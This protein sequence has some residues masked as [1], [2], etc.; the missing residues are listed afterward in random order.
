MQDVP[1]DTIHPLDFAYTVFVSMDDYRYTALDLS[2][3]GRKVDS[4]SLVQSTVNYS[5]LMI[6]QISQSV[7]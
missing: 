6:P 7:S 3:V 4:E 5:T 2:Q 1:Q